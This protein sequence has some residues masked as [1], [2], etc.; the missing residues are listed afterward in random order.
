MQNVYQRLAE[1]LDTFPH[2]FPLHT[3]SGIELK[4]LQHI[5]TPE[6]AE[7]F[8]KLKAQPE[9]AEQIA[10]RLGCTPGAAEQTLWEMSKKGQVF[11]TGKEGNRRYMA[12]SFLVG[13]VEF[14]MNR[15][16]P[17]FARDFQE[18]EPILYAATW[19]RGATRDLRTIP[20]MEALDPDTQVMPYEKV[21]ETI[22]SAKIIA[23]SDCMCRRLK[24]LVGKPCS[25]PLEA[26]FH[27]GS[28]SHYFV[29]N[30][31]GR[32][33]SQDEALAILKKGK[34]SGLVCQIGASQEPNA[35]CMCCPC[36][37][38]PLRACKEHA[39]PSE[40]VN[41]N[42]FAR[43]L[44]D[45]C[46]ECEICAEACPMEAI[47]VDDAAR[48]NLERCIG[49]GVCAV[50]CPMDAIKLFRKEK[51]KEFVPEK[52]FPSSTAA[53]HRQRREP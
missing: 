50:N 13:L 32:Y 16:T 19:M 31:I 18:F 36:C 34:E 43:V 25:H 27:F 15:M 52:D 7:I 2:R 39:R 45:I 20:I 51:E 4:I 8:L 37:C 44:E 6:E 53:I 9:A 10:G 35:L 29:E 38:G 23:V 17:E 49:C 24:G 28:G 3:E 33:I 21:E 14:Q 47:T 22:R 11:R 30:G 46:T 1:F 5:F 12:T 41:S 48:I 42:F 40:V 26:C